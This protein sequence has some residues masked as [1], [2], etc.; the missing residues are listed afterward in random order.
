MRLL[1]LALLGTLAFS[2]VLSAA[3]RRR[4]CGNIPTGSYL[5]KTLAV[6][7]CAMRRR[8]RPTKRPSLLIMAMSGSM[9]RTGG[10]GK[11]AI[12]PV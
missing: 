9:F 3:A 1:A 10:L 6:N 4:S 8:K 7:A 12:N 11:P 2:P 5:Q